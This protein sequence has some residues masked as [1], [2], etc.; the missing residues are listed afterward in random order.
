MPQISKLQS[1]LDYDA[2]LDLP[3]A[4]ARM[5]KELETDREALAQLKTV[6][7]LDWRHSFDETHTSMSFHFSVLK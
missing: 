1:Q 4:V 7:R 5:E 3:G 6:D 2:Q